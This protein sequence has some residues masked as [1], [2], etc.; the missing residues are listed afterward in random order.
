MQGLEFNPSTTKERKK[1]RKRERR[2]ERRKEGRKEGREEG[3]K[4]ENQ[5]QPGL[6]IFSP[7]I[8]TVKTGL[9]R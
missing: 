9:C 2:K 4:E 6:F 3:R 5:Y 8:F 1:E 7:C